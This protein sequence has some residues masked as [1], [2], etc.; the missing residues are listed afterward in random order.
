MSG[1]EFR[2][3]RLPE[4]NRYKALAYFAFFFNGPTKEAV[5]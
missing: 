1:K 4:K 2:E 5:P 3:I